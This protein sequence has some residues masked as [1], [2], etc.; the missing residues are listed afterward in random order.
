[1]YN[2]FICPKCGKPIN[3]H[4]EYNCGYPIIVYRCTNCS[5]DSSNEKIISDNKTTYINKNIYNNTTIIKEE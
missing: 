1:M 4:I 2:M 5:Y 3:G